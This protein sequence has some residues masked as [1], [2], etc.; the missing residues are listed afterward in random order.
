M[1]MQSLCSEATAMARKISAYL[2][3]HVAIV[4]ISVA[5]AKDAAAG[6]IVETL[7]QQTA[8]SKF[9]RLLQSSGLEAELE[10]NG[11]FTV[12][13]PSDA[14]FEAASTE[15]INALS[16]PDDGALARKMV[17]SLI[18]SARWAPE[19]LAGRRLI[20]RGLVGKRI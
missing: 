20:S 4:I 6:D 18:V 17:E 5:A 13:A 3:F 1:L 10:G 8:F 14:A 12:F 11:S 7:R 2:F 9:T 15:M 16:R 19:D